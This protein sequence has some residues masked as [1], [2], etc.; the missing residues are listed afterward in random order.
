MPLPLDPTTLPPLSAEELDRLKC[1]IQE[2]I[3]PGLVIILGSG[4]S[5]AEGISGM[6][7]LATH[8]LTEIPPKLTKGMELSWQP[9]A[10]KLSTGMGLED[11]LL[12]HPP[13][14]AIETLI[15]AAT[16][17]LIRRDEAKVI[18]EVV[19]QSRTLRLTRLLRQFISWSEPVDM[20][21]P[22]YDRL[23]EF[24]AEDAGLGVDTMFVGNALGRYDEAACD[25]GF[26][27][28]LQ[29]VGRKS[30]RPVMAPRIRLNKPHGSLDWTI[31]GDKPIRIAPEFNP[32]PLIITPGVN[33][34]LHGY[35]V[36]FDRHRERGNAC[37]DR[38]SR[39]LVIGFGF[40]D[41]H[42]ETHLSPAIRAGKPTLI[43][44]HTLSVQAAQLIGTCANVTGLEYGTGA[45]GAGTVVRR[46]AG[47]RFL[48]G[49]N[50]WD[51]GD[52]VREVF[53]G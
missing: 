33:K 37:I 19:A 35:S 26:L 6:G 3:T 1:Q 23:A 47:D 11:V 27:K 9:I 52:L 7:T 15:V 49:V 32:S 53:G 25:L 31:R 18:R 24:A 21:T 38:A 45:G 22:N 10:D 2:F 30:F 42:L 13:T 16:A 14:E 41:R 40:N 43:L 5:A 48:P 12:A 39:F 8:L 17:E 36:P 34:Y 46:L 50:L 20:V 51:L 29:P 44:T 4:L 28:R